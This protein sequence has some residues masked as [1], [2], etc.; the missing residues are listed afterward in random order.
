MF[1][2]SLVALALCMLVLAPLAPM[3][4]A[5]PVGGIKYAKGRV[6]ARSTDTYS[7]TCHGDEPTRV[8]VFGDG[9][10]DLDVYVYDADDNLVG[11]DDDYTDT[12]IVMWIPPKTGEFSIRIRNL[13]TVYNNYTILVD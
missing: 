13:G 11:A 7:V 12:C 10:T 1:R 4:T 9:D 6:E 8:F 3:A 2:R 5:K